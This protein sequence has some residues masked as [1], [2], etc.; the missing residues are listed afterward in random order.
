MRLI[1]PWLVMVVVSCAIAQD[2]PITPIPFSKVTITDQFW[3]KKIKTNHDVTIP[4]AIQK[5]VESGRIDNFKKAAGLM[6]GPFGT[7]Y[8]FDDSDVFKIIEAASYSLQ[9]YPDAKLEATIDTLIDYITKAQ[10]PDGYLYTNRTI[11]EGTVHPWAGD[12]RW[13]N[14]NELSHELYNLGHM[15]EAAAAHFIA[16]GKKTFLNVAIKSA[17]LVCETFGPGKIE[18]YPGHQEIEIGLVKLY[19]IT[20]NTRYLD[21]AKYFL[22]A[23]GKE[24]VGRPDKYNQSHLP[25][26]QQT[27]AVGHSVRASYMWTAMADVAAITGNQDYVK[28]INTLWHDVV[29][30][31]YYINGG[32]GSTGSHEGFGAQYELPNLTA[33]NETCAGVGNATW[34]HRMFLMTGDAKYM[35]VLERTMFNNILTGV[36]F[37]GNTFFYPNPLASMGQYERSE[38]FGCAC[39]PPNVARFLPSMPG[40][41]YAQKGDEV[42]VNLYISN[43]ST[44]Q[45]PGGNL[46]IQQESSLPWEGHAALS[47]VSEDVVDA[48]L[49]L[50]IPGWARNEPSPG[51]LYEYVDQPTKPTVVKVNG[52]VQNEEVDDSGYVTLSRAWKKNDQITLDFPFEVRKVKARSEVT[53]DRGKIAI[54]RGPMLYCAEEVDNGTVQ[55]LILNENASFKVEFDQDLFGG[56]MI[57][58]TTARKASRDRSGRVNLSQ[59][60]PLKLIP[61]HLWSN[62]GPGEMTVWIPTSLETTRPAPA[63]TIA[64]NSKITASRGSRALYTVVDQQVPQ[65][66]ADKSQPVYDWWPKKGSWEWVDF[67]FEKDHKISK[68]KV[69]WL[70]DTPEGEVALPDQWEVQYRTTEANPQADDVWKSV[71]AKKKYNVTKDGWNEII[72]NEVNAL[73]LRVKVKLKDQYSAGIHEIVIE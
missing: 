38:W 23:R 67:A 46:T 51:G 17:D 54:E 31:K 1:L 29:D 16:T 71:K 4:I 15:Y 49:K 21:A 27:E 36:S 48:K 12:K 9:V 24:G 7:E 6:P 73:G 41:I 5:S 45:L 18:N 64:T 19:R 59:E 2:Y 26:T 42:F 66:S 32:I 43:Q 53:E 70:V 47:I 72:F 57:I 63:S 3:S 52:Q 20:K 50:R 58:K 69:Y 22:D 61:Y 8:P 35:D 62:R 34:N 68:V 13:M 60:V 25:V 40:Y 28:A 14:V 10:E 33:Y 11:K 65:N 55:N 44:L 39:C 56:T 30:T 37:E